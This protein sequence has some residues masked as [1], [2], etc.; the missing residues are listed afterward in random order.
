MKLFMI[1]C[2]L[3]IV[4]ITVYTYKVVRDLCIHTED[5]LIQ[6][7]IELAKVYYRIEQIEDS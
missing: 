4:G 6:H 5:I 7:E 1:V 3:V 2:V